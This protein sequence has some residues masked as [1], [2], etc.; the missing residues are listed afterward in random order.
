MKTL[1]QLEKEMKAAD[2][3]A[4][5]AW[6]TYTAEYSAALAARDAYNAAYWAAHNPNQKNQP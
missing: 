3:A 1:K 4:L 2:A 5:A 6:D